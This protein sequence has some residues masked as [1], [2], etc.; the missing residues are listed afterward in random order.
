MI[1]PDD[2][3][4][5]NVLKGANAAALYGSV[6]ANGVL[7]ITTKKGREGRMSV[8]VSS[9]VTFDNPLTTPKIQNIYGAAVNESARTM[10]TYS[11]G[12]RLDSRSSS[13]LLVNI[14]D[15]QEENANFK[16]QSNTVHLRNVAN[17]DLDDFYR[18]GVTTNN[19]VALSG[20]T[21]KM[22]TYFSYGNSHSKGYA[23][24]QLLQPSHILIPSELQV[25]RSFEHQ[26]VD[27]LHPG[28]DKEP[29]WWWYC[30]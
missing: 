26:C 25:L 17:N 23:R 6:A 13:N 30:A 29:S 10:D 21:E 15:S 5:I 27:E 11:W 7:M 20:G 9:N 16:G 1:N 4:S 18:T 22:D 3:E 28:Q 14:A 19:S 8:N 12:D 24:A 2:I